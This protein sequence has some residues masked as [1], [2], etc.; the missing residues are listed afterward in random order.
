M[1]LLYV[2]VLMCLWARGRASEAIGLVKDG[3]RT[4]D[5]SIIA[6]LI[7]RVCMCTEYRA[8]TLT[9]KCIFLY[10][11]CRANLLCT[12]RHGWDTSRYV[13]ILLLSSSFDIMYAI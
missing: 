7:A 6:A 9:Y 13:F 11:N 12:W 5:P 8:M 4:L 10:Y 1:E 2:S 3:R